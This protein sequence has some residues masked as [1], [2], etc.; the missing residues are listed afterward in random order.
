MKDLLPELRY[1][2]ARCLLAVVRF[3]PYPAVLN[4]FRALAAVAWLVLPYHRK[5]AAVQMRAALGVRHA[6][7]LTLKVF[8]NQAEILVDAI[9][10]AYLSDEEIRARVVVEGKEHLHEALA[11]GRGLMMITGHIGNWEILSH[12]PRLL[13]VR[14]CV[15][16]D[17][18]KD[19]RLEAIVDDIRSRSGATIL[20][21]TGKALML[22][23]ELRK[24]NTIG[25]VVDGRGEEKDGLSCDVFGMPAPTNPAPAFIAIKGNALV[26]PVAAVKVRG[27]YHVTFSSPVDAASCG[28]GEEAVRDLSASMQS[29]VE[30]VVREN[31]HQWFWLYSRWVKRADMRR[32]LRKGLDFRS[33]VMKQG[34]RSVK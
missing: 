7:L 16:A 23:R 11:S 21:P 2:A 28:T 6:R 18:R 27:T 24:G 15:M 1:R 26:L 25:V 14:F 9:R 12:L 31:P 20:P 32:I 8:M 4:L 17:R 5:V 34:D 30:S 19:P 33:F 10:Y 13:P 29:W 3:L 22:I